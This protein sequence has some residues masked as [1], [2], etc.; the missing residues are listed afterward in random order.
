MELFAKLLFS[1]IPIKKKRQIR[2]QSNVQKR[3]YRHSYCKH[4]A[5]TLEK[6][7]AVTGVGVVFAAVVGVV[8]RF[9]VV[10]CNL[11]CRLSCTPQAHWC[12]RKKEASPK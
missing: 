3:R 8:G 11:Y 12:S 9:F 5:A 7:L 4:A 10:C 2:R 1:Y 6:A